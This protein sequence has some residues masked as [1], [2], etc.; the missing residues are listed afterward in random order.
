MSYMATEYIIASPVPEVSGLELDLHNL[1][2]RL[3]IQEEWVEKTRQQI[4]DLEELISQ[5]KKK[6]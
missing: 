3:R 2:M 4:S 1:K 6:I 5:E